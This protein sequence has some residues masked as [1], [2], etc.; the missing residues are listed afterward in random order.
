[1]LRARARVLAQSGDASGLAGALTDEAQVLAPGRGRAEGLLRAGEVFEDRLG[2]DAL[3]EKL[4]T[5]AVSEDA[6][7]YDAHLGV[8]RVQARRRDWEG[9]ATTYSVLAAAPDEPTHRLYQGE[10][11]WLRGQTEAGEDVHARTARYLAAARSGIP[12]EPAGALAEV[13]RDDT[14]AAALHVSAGLSEIAAGGDARP[15]LRAAMLRARDAPEAVWLL[16]QLPDGDP[17]ERARVLER[18]AALTEGEVR[19]QLALERAHTLEQAGRLAE[20]ARALEEVLLFDPK[21]VPALAALR[22]LCRAASDRE[23]LWRA[24]AHLG[25]ALE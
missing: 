14:L 7:L 3:A 22:R 8:A 12:A 1:A 20:A 16:A 21:H 4:Y 19:A 9:L 10:V 13:V 18:A 15:G 23:G 5:N 24:C 17:H 25:A 11:A 2:D 6:T